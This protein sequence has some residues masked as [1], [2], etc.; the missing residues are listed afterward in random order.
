M[1]GNSEKQEPREG[2][3]KV[4]GIRSEFKNCR[5]MKVTFL[6]DEHRMGEW[7]NGLFQNSLHRPQRVEIY[8]F[9]VCVN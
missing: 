3:K 7:D 5:R 6:I 2:T 9:C 8:F 1:T 4:C